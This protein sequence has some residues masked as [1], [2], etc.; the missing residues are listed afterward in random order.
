[1]ARVRTGEDNE[2]ILRENHFSKQQ[3]LPKVL[4]SVV[5]C[6]LSGAQTKKDLE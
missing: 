5:L 4:M 6:G 1:V 3:L 2:A